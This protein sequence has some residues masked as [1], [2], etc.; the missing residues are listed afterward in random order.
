MRA[1]LARVAEGGGSEVMAELNRLTSPR[2]QIPVGTSL[3]TVVPRQLV[4]VCPKVPGQL[5]RLLVEPGAVVKT[6]DLLAE[7]DATKYKLEVER[8]QARVAVARAQVQETKAGAASS[9]RMAVVEAKLKVAEAELRL[10]EYAIEATQVRAPIDGTILN[11]QADVGM[12]V[13][14][15]R[16]GTLFEIADLHDVVVAAN[17]PENVRDV[18]FP[19]QPCRIQRAGSTEAHKGKVLRL[20]PAADPSTATYP[21]WVKVEERGDLL[22][23]G[24]LVS[25]EF[26]GKQ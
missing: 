5:V 1:L 26:L 9:A 20:Y 2:V 7:V 14:P 16:S 19:S 11:R 4:L 15:G 6:G 21:V 12:V 17:V 8:L 13:E 3:G 25:V 10:G 24:C 18:L 23:P 22:R